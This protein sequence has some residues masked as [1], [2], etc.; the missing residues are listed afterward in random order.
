[1]KIRK[2]FFYKIAL[3]VFGISFVIAQNNPAAETGEIS[4]ISLLPPLV[5]ILLALLTRQTIISLFAGIWIGVSIMEKSFFGGL[6]TAL[7]TYVVNALSDRGHSSIILFSLGFGGM[8]G[9]I[10]A[11]GGM[12]GIIKSASKYAKSGRSGQ[13]STAIMGILIF[14]DD[15]AN[16]L[17]VGNMMRP[18]SDKL[19]ISREKLSYIVDSTAAPVASIAVISTWSV[20]QMSLLTGPF[21]YFGITGNPYITFL[22]S[23]PYSFYCLFTLAFVFIN[24][25]LRKEYGPMYKAQLRSRTTGAVLAAGANPMVETTLGELDLKRPPTHPSNAFIPIISVIFLTMAGLYITGVNALGPQVDHSFKNIISGSDSYA[26]LMW[27]SF[28]TCG[29]AIIL[30]VGK[31]LLTLQKAMEAWVTGIRSMVMAAIILVLAWTLGNV[32]EHIGTADYLVNLTAGILTPAILPSITFITAA[33]ISFS[34]GSSWATMSIMVPIITPLSIQLIG[35]DPNLVIQ[36]PYFIATFA[37]ILSGATFGDHCSPIS[38]TT[39]LSSM[40]TGADHIDHVRTQLPYAMTTG[41]IA[42]L[43]GFVLIGFGVPLWA[44]LLI[45][46]ASVW[47]IIQFAGKTLPRTV[48]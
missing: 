16:T 24:I 17:L 36:T 8:I 45:G 40:A 26:A 33:A 31:R 42:L 41:F 7:D 9:I 38:D 19:K 48:V 11:N 35:L 27:S 21:Q 12:R 6:T 18:F 30:S 28:L 20:F 4:W 32:C 37:A 46:L 34:T 10:S 14:F 25:S 5:S 22:K 43:S 47:A 39:I 2:L 23:I 13:M 15:Y 3:L 44:T 1:M 29:I